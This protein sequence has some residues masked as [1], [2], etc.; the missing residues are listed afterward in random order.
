MF[1]KM[2]IPSFLGIAIFFGCVSVSH[3]AHAADVCNPTVSVKETKKTSINLKVSCSE[4]KK[5]KV[6]VK[7]LITNKDT[8]SD[9][10]KTVSTTLGKN[11]SVKLKINGLDSATNYEFKVKIKKK[12]GG[13]YSSYS[14]SVEADTDSS[15]YE[16]E[17]EKIGSI[18]EDSVKLSI[19]S[20]DLEN[21]TVN[22]L[23]AY[24]KK[25]SWSTK[26]A[27]LTLD[28][29]GDGSITM[30]G[31]KSD[32]LYNFKIKKKKDEDSVYSKYSDIKTATTDDD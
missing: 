12:S 24:K 30:D 21:E 10:N 15:D 19:S 17:I 11:G 32:T 26:T 1:S 5:T 3:S 7:I 23:V 22:V 20:E 13:S 14:D 2:M 18:T 25:T 16:A 27:T 28:G 29:D 8:N 9:S 31:L 6:K 4:L